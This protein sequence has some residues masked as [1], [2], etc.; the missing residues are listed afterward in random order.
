MRAKFTVVLKDGK[1]WLK[2]D[3]Y[4]VTYLKI[5]KANTAAPYVKYMGIIAPLEP[6]MIDQLR[7]LTK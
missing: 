5:W 2:W 7:E 3:Q 1:P 6:Y 4:E